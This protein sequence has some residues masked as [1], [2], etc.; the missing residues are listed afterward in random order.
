MSFLSALNCMCCLFSL[1]QVIIDYTIISSN[2]S[3]T[4]D[5]LLVSDCENITQS[6]VI[7]C[8]FRDHLMPY[9]TRKVT[10]DPIGKHNTVR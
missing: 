9:C 2:V 6:G 1:K 4:I 3:T 7:D 5:L 8:C 10:S